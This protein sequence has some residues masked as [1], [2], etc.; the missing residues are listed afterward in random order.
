MGNESNEST[1]RNRRVFEHA[2][3]I[4]GTS[5]VTGVFMNIAGKVLQ[6]NELLESGANIMKSVAVSPFY[7]QGCELLQY[8][9]KTLNVVGEWIRDFS[10]KIMT[11]PTGELFI[12]SGR[13]IAGIGLVIAVAAFTV[14]A[15]QNEVLQRMH[16]SDI[17]KSVT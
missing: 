10:F 8:N 11:M 2:V 17:D 12:E 16:E 1:S 5:V 14:G 15:L 7:V 13:M 6:Q 9:H 4:L 3:V